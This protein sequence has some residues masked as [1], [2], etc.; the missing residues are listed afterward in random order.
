MKYLM[1]TSSYTSDLDTYILNLLSF[2]LTIP[3]EIVIGMPNIGFTKVVDAGEFST[4]EQENINLLEETI[5][6]LN[7]DGLTVSSFSLDPYVIK[8]EYKGKEY[9][10]KGRN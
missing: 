3:K 7:I 6:S 1:T 2:V 4:I 9:E 5:R 8:V 10:I